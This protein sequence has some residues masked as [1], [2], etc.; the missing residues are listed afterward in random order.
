MEGALGSLKIAGLD[1]LPEAARAL[2]TSAFERAVEVHY[3]D[4]GD[5][6][7]MRLVLVCGAE[8]FVG[9]QLTLELR[10]LQSVLF[11]PMG[12]HLWLPQ[13]DITEIRASNF[14]GNRMLVSAEEGSGFE[15]Y[16]GSV[17]LISFAAP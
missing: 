9:W 5:G 13:L 12:P 1:K 3:R 11:P 4:P 10:D 17:E 2:S 6:L 14:E 8:P 15:C 7:S 16:C